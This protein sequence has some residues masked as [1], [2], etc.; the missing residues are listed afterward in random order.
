LASSFSF[1]FFSS[2]SRHTRSD[3]DWSSDVCSSD[4]H[5]P[6]P[7][8]DAATLSG[9]P[10][11]PVDPAYFQGLNLCPVT[12]RYE[13]ACRMLS[14]KASFERSEERRV[15]KECRARWWACYEKKKI[16]CSIKSEE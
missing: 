10:Q 15:G 12:Y 1:F 4:L 8:R 11:P 5:G 13:P 2:R 3:R 9:I 6:E 7:Q 16:E 14:R